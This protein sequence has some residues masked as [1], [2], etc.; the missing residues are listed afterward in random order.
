MATCDDFLRQ[1]IALARD[2]V[3]QGG[4]PFGAILVIDGTVAATG[5]NEIHRN[6]DPTA[7]AEMMAL[8]AAATGRGSP[9]LSGAVMYASGHPCPM[10]LAAMR[11]SGIRDIVYAYSNDDGAPYGLTTAPLYAE[12][13]KPLGDQAMSFTYD[14][15]RL[16]GETDVYDLWRE[17]QQG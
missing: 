8:R 3:G 7:H 1:A 16:E 9:D 4:R 17:M 14:P 5:V 12:L 15:V 13:R 2:N 6:G 10:C 11:L